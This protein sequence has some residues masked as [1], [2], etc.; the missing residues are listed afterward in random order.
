MPSPL[1][2]R[3]NFSLATFVYQLLNETAEM[4]SARK[5]KNMTDNPKP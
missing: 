1:L 2:R 4:L 3:L 5:H